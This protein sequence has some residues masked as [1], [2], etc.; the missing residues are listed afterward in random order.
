MTKTQKRAEYL[1]KSV[2]T[3]TYPNS[4]GPKGGS[5][6]CGL[7]GWMAMGHSGWTTAA[8]AAGYSS[9]NYWSGSGPTP[10][11]AFPSAVVLAARNAPDELK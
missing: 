2:G 11:Q 8:L 10:S 3:I 7:P 9:R 6:V 4:T 1:R 5:N